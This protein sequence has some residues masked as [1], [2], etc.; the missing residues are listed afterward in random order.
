MRLLSLALLFP[1]L[2]PAQKISGL[3][4]SVYDGNTLEVRGQDQEFYRVVLLGIDCPEL[5]Q[6]YGSNAKDLLE[7]FLLNQEVVLNLYGKDRLR[8]YIGVVLSRD[9]SDIRRQL[10]EEGLA[11]TA[12]ARPLPDLELLRIA[13]ARQRRGLWS[14]SNPIPPWIYRRQQSMS[15]PKAR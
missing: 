6:R 7:K 13:S 9:S 12:E 15:V 1:L 2:S 5:G 4:T 8:N 3:V 10:L 14:E 11:W